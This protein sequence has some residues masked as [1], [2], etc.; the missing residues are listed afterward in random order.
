MTHE[1][2]VL[3]FIHWVGSGCL[4]ASIVTK[5]LPTPEEIPNRWY[6]IGYNVLRR[7]SVN[8]AWKNGER[9]ARP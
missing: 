9:S 7:M 8:S 6:V 3:E 4:L 5:F 2:F 1:Q